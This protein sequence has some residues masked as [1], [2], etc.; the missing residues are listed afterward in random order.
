MSLVVCSSNHDVKEEEK[1]IEMLVSKKMD[2]LLLVGAGS[3]NRVLNSILNKVKVV[4][5]DRVYEGYDAPYVV[6]DNYNG[7]KKL[8]WY[9]VK[10][11]HR[12]F[13]FLNG[14]EGTYS[15]TERLRG[16]VDALKEAG[17]KDYVVFFGQ[18]TYESGFS[19]VKKLGK[20]P[21][22]VVCGNDLMAYGAIDALEE[23]GYEVPK[24]VSVTGFDDLP[25]SKHYK[26]SLTTV[27]QPFHAMGY[28]SAKILHWMISGKNKKNKKIVLETE[29]IIREST[30]G[31]SEYETS[32]NS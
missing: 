19:L 23:M 21:D 30:K 25:F 28:E 14:E 16:F 1:L 15:A 8:V 3:S 20:I 10:T 17:I 5:V 13:A 27:R 7:M 6:S 32:G 9:L 22:A 31:G 11:G 4:F 29:L 26:P 12:S 2:G 24:N 18:F